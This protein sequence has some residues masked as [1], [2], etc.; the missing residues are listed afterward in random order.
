MVKKVLQAKPEPKAPA[1]SELVANRSCGTCSMCCKIFDIPPIEG[2][3]AGT[4]C[5]HCRPGSGCGIWT[6]RPQMC[7][8]YFCHWRFDASLGPEWR[9]DVAKFLI[10]REPGGIWLSVIVD[11]ALPNAWRREPYH[12]KLRTLAT[13]LIEGGSHG[14]M[15]I[16]GDSKYVILPDREVLIGNKDTHANVR[17]KRSSVNGAVRYDV[18]LQVAA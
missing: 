4:W 9:P 17:F 5:K 16:V 18:E 8:D 14:L 1:Q 6:E 12:T 11:K 3:L 13:R 7:A 10:N 2:K 15:L